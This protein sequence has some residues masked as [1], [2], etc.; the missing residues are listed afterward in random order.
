MLVG[1]LKNNIQ[2]AVII[3][4]LT[5]IFFCAIIFWLQLPQNTV[6]TQ[7]E[8]IL[9]SYLFYGIK[10]VVFKKIWLFIVILIGALALNFIAINQ[11]ITTKN[12][13]L[14]AFLYTLLAYASSTSYIIEPILIANIFVLIALYFMLTSYRQDASLTLCY[15]SGFFIGLAS[16][17]YVYYVLLF[18]VFFIALLILR[19]FAWREYALLLFGMITPIYFYWAMGYLSNTV[20]INLFSVFGKLL[21]SIQ[22]IHLSEYFI[23][24][25]LVLMLLMLLAVFQNFSSGFGV[26]V[27]TQKFKFILFW[28]FGVSFLMIFFNH[29]TQMLLLPCIVP[30]SIII[31][32]YLAEI[33]KIKI[34]NTLLVLFFLAYIIFLSKPLGLL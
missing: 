20:V 7:S 19:T 6:N 18:P 33:K 28:I 5:S 16:F 9:Y 17:F 25:F 32:D 11:E 31:G 10:W 22:K 29:T 34:A 21:T 2:F 4:I 27:K 13:F 15:N 12:N 30:L 8:H 26:K 24:L 1:T 3:N 14:P 23:A